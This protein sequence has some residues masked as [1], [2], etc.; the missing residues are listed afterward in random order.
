MN[1]LFGQAC[2][3]PDEPAAAAPDTEAVTVKVGDKEVALQDLITGDKADSIKVDVGDGKLVTL[4]TFREAARRAPDTQK[5]LD[6]VKVE[7]EKLAADRAT[8]EEE[9]KGLLKQVE[10]AGKSQQISVADQLRV[11]LSPKEPQSPFA[12]K[13]AAQAYISKRLAE[14]YTGAVTEVV[15]KLMDGETATK[16]EI[17]NL[18]K[19]FKDIVDSLKAEQKQRDDARILQEDWDAAKVAVPELGVEGWEDL[20]SLTAQLIRDDKPNQKVLGGRTG[21][22]MPAADVAKMAK[23]FLDTKWTGIADAKAAAK[24][25]AERTQAMHIR[26]T[27]PASVEPSSQM[28][29]LNDAIAKATTREDK[30]KLIQQKYDLAN[31]EAA[32]T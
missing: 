10:E 22:D 31:K 17:A 28:K 1:R 13:E 20:T 32:A 26:P 24:A 8:M 18:R 30:M 3:S 19:E 16:T 2:Y 7:R 9:R 21:A 29:S 27:G 12:S 6:E 4:K 25:E 14:D 15:G 23:A 5:I 11:L